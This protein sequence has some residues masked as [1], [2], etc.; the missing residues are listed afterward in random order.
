[1]GSD[2]TSPSLL[3]RVRDPGDATAWREFDARYGE[4]ILR[5]GRRCG[6]QHSDAEDVRQMVMQKLSRALR[7]FEYEPGRGRFRSFLWCI[8]RN[9]LARLKGRPRVAPHRVTTDGAW[10]SEAAAVESAEQ[11]WEEEW[12]HHHLRLAMRDIRE[13]F[14]PRSVQVFE[15]LLAGSSV[16]TIAREFRMTPDAVH[17]VKQRVRNRLKHLI[18]AQIRD[19]DEPHG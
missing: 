4:L 17:K 11:R 18:A 15:A 10:L 7:S 1:M 8:V 9:E 13:R 12:T 6:L 14:D 3:R 19:E 2:T 16:N 5:F